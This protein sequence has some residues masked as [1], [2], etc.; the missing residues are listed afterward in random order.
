M[1]NEENVNYVDE[2]EQILL[3]NLLAT[4]KAR[5]VAEIKFNLANHDYNVARDAMSN[6]RARRRLVES[7]NEVTG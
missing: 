3:D 4:S 2:E 7:I 6:F 1:K 5:S